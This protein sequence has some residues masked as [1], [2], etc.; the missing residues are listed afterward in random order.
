M[1][2]NNI[3]TKTCLAVSLFAVAGCS[4]FLDEENIASQSA[5]QFYSTADGYE[6]LITGAYSTLKSVYNTTNY[7]QLTQLGTD[8]GT[9]NDGTSTNVLNQYTVDYAIDNDAVY[10]QWK[11]LYEAL[12]NVNAA[13][14]R[15]GSVKTTDE[16]IFE[17]I[18]ADIL[19]KRVAEEKFLRALY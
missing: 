14:N 6:T 4:S 16:D 1:R 9:Q 12:K 13:I 2:T 5:E 8:L 17:G 10:S 7:F 3:L 18:D 15:A 11:A 19:A